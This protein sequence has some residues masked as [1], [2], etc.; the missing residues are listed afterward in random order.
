[1]F[2]TISTKGTAFVDEYGRT[3]VFNGVNYVFKGEKPEADGIVHFQNPLTT[4]NLKDLKNKGVNILRLGLT[5]AGVEPEMGKYNDVYLEEYRQVVR[6]AAKEGIYVFLDW[7]Q[8]LFSGFGLGVGDGAPAWACMTNKKMSKPRFIWA[9]GYFFGGAV[10]ECFDA[11]WENRPLAGRGLRDRFCDMLAYTVRFMK[12]EPNLMGFDVL[13]E[14]YPG[15]EGGKIFRTLV[16]HGAGTLLGLP[17]KEKVKRLKQLTGKQV[18]EALE[19]LDEPKVYHGIIDGATKRLNKF[20]TG[21][22]YDFLCAA[23]ESIRRVTDKGVLFF[24]NSYYGN[25]GIPCAVPKPVYKNGLREKNL[26][27]APHGYDLT[28]DSPL[29]NKASTRRVDF[30]FDEHR[31]KQTRMG[32]PVLVGEWG[33]MVA[34]GDEYPALEHLIAKFDKNGWSQTYWHYSRE[35]AD[36]KIFEILNRPHPRAVAGTDLDYGFDRTANAF[37]LTYTGGQNEKPTEIYLPTAPKSVSA[38][39]GYRVTDEDGCFLLTVPAVSGDVRV[40]VTL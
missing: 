30:I 8:D 10:F 37:T 6:D 38:P 18:M 31:R 15:S 4:E 7:H 3:R 23:G 39:E 9:E 35:I 40:Q 13:N 5:W 21:V 32:L 36:S 12:D 26:A 24:E 14:P 2:D 29:T 34:G 17:A 11:F 1:M 27:F 33:G 22:Y 25:L 16:R 19:V 28:V 20:D